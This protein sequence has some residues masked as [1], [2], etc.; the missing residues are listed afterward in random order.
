MRRMRVMKFNSR[1]G[2][3]HFVFPEFMM[4]KS[5]EQKQSVDETKAKEVTKVEA[6]KPLFMVREE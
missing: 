6:A 3:L 5:N 2:D 1:D 4:E